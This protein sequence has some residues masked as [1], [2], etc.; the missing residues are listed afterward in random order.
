VSSDDFSIDVD[1][2]PLELEGES[3]IQQRIQRAGVES[4]PTPPDPDGQPPRRPRLPLVLL[5]LVM[6]LAAVEVGA[7]LVQHARVP[8]DADWNAAARKVRAERKP[9]EPVLFAPHWVAPLGRLHLGDQLPMELQLLSDVDRY[10]RVFEVSIRGARHPWLEGQRAT[11]SWQL[12]GVRVALYQRPTPAQVRFD[13]T[14]NVRQA[15]V[16]RIG[17]DVVHCPFRAT[18]S[19]FACDPAR[20]WNWVGSYLAEVNHQP[21]RCIFVNPVDGH[22]MRITFPAVVL[23]G[24]LVGYTGIDDFENRKRS[25]EPVLLKTLVGPRQ[26]GAIQH[27]ND[28]PWHR[29]TIDTHELAGQTHPVS[30]EVTA[31]RAYARSFCFSA[32][33]RK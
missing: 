1:E 7:T 6:L 27:Q 12:G 4:G 29:F 17:R 2:A 23:G 3:A 20:G 11:S 28:W 10:P 31:T 32:E 13:F 24:S 21:Y 8:S 5:A 16:T 22:V 30:F 33:T 15:Q 19:R 18:D 25:K 9:G 26:V 14:H